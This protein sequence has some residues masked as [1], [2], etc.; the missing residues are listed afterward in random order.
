M[1]GR[2]HPN[3]C[4][5][6]ILLVVDIFS[7]LAYFMMTHSLYVPENLPTKLWLLGKYQQMHMYWTQVYEISC[8]SL[9]IHR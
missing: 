8:S 7:S 9:L 6:I 1:H 5:L 2:M 4:Q 3:Y